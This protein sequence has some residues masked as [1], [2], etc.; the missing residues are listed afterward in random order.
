MDHR[1]FHRDLKKLRLHNPDI[2]A[3][4]AKA[5]S[6][7]KIL[8]DFHKKWTTQN[9]MGLPGKTLR[10]SP[11]FILSQGSGAWSVTTDL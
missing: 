8:A 4:A 11:I 9:K 6:P 5:I 3:N 10:D 1:P 2:P 7:F